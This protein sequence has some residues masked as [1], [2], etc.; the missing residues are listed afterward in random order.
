MAAWRGALGGARRLAGILRLAPR[1]IGHG[2]LVRTSLLDAGL[3][4]VAGGGEKT[5]F[6]VHSRLFAG[7]AIRN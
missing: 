1:R 6:G 2:A 4:G 5:R 3:L 7:R